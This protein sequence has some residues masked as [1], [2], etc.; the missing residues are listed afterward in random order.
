MRKPHPTTNMTLQQSA[1][2]YEQVKRYLYHRWAM[3]KQRGETTDFKTYYEL[4]KFK[5]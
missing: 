5:Y 3:L 1:N 2:Y 4:R